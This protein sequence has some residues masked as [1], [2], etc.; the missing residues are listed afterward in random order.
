[1]RKNFEKKSLK[2]DIRYQNHESRPD[3]AGEHPVGDT[4][5]IIAFIIFVIA[6]L[7]DCLYLGTPSLLK[8]FI[9]LWIRLPASFILLIIGAWLSLYGIHMVFSEY[10]EDPVMIT[11]GMFS[12]IRH[13]I[14]LGAII[15]YLAVLLLTL[16]IP[17]II[18]WI[19]A[20][21][22]YNWLARDEEERMLNVFGME[23][24]DYK[25]KVPM[26]LPRIRR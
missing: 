19:F 18:V 4:L 10:R 20:I 17:G 23:Y 22:L 14:Y 24:R 16:S 26:W 1:M 7:L 8:K 21:F 5:Q 13:P 9:P 2:S 12:H 6:T 25:Q 11:K 15:F 3:L